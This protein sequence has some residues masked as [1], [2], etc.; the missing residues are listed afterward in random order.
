MG[1]III[2]GIIS[3]LGILPLFIVVALILLFLG[4]SV[5]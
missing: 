1:D 2:Q 3:V 5:K 4:K